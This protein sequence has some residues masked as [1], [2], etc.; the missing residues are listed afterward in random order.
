MGGRKDGHTALFKSLKAAVKEQCAVNHS[1]QASA[2]DS[3]VCCLCL[4]FWYFGKYMLS[5]SW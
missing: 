5:D 3:L 2:H 4:S 1:W